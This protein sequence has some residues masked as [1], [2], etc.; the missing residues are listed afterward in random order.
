MGQALDFIGWLIMLW[1]GLGFALGLLLMGLSHLC[2]WLSGK[3]GLS[4]KYM[5]LVT[6]LI[7]APVILSA[8][9]KSIFFGGFLYGLLIL[10]LGLGCDLMLELSDRP[11]VKRLPTWGLLGTL[12]LPFALLALYALS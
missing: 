12:I 11:F 6:P 7:L 3:I 2:A 5:A 1:A 9:L 4:L 10:L 8:S